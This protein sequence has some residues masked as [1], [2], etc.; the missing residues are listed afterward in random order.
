M[1]QPPQIDGVNAFKFI[2]NYFLAGCEPP[3]DLFCQF[4]QEPAKDVLMLLLLPDLVDIGQA[5]FDPRGGRRRK[6]ARH[7]RKKPF[8]LGFP[9]ASDIIGQRTRGIINPDNVLSYG[10]FTRVFRVWNAYEGVAFSAAVIDG[11]SNVGYSG[12]WGILNFDPNHCR[13]LE[14]L[15]KHDDDFWTTGGPGG[16]VHPVGIDIV[17]FNNGFGHTNFACTT[18]DNK[19]QIN[20]RAQFTNNRT[21]IRA[22]GRLG[23][24]N[25]TTGQVFTS[26]HFD[27]GPRET[28][29]REVHGE[30][31]AGDWCTWGF[32]DTS[33]F[34]D[35]YDRSILAYSEHNFPFPW[36]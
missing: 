18:I 19:F 6:P 1:P 8:R 12:L 20:F 31:P 34:V 2:T 25:Q 9:D 29:V 5:I 30:F 28:A 23:L 35:V 14:R 13:N 17:D 33:G 3:F 7:G 11:L 15:A 4:S 26:N 24:E 22:S 36:L 10:P 27:L 21:D 32:Y 16:G